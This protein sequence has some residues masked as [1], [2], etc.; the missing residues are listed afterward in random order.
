MA[1]AIFSSNQTW[2]NPDCGLQLFGTC[3]PATGRETNKADTLYSKRFAK[4][5]AW[6]TDLASNLP[7]R[8]YKFYRFITSELKVFDEKE[9]GV[10]TFLL[11]KVTRDRRSK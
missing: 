9:L 5:S 1:I 7:G 10:G 11:A 4:Y 3:K 6:K 8:D 2:G